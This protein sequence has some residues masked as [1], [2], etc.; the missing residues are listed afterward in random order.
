MLP[1]DSIAQ[2]ESPPAKKYQSH[3]F[4]VIYHIMT[5]IIL[6]FL[7]KSLFLE[8]LI[9]ASDNYWHP[10]ATFEL[11]LPPAKTVLYVCR[12]VAYIRDF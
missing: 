6:L 5:G 4:S 1:V 10:T 7:F 2:W 11:L 8:L 9:L 3:S 12:I